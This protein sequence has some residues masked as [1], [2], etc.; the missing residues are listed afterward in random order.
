MVYVQIKD[1]MYY[2]GFGIKQKRQCI[3]AGI[4]QKREF[5]ICEFWLKDFR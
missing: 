5:I 4:K 3:I 2:V 1:Q